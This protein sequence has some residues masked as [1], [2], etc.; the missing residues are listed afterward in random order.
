MGVT[1]SILPI[2]KPA[3]AIA[4]M[5]A[6]APGP[7]VLGPVP[8]TAL[9]LMWTAV[10]PFDLATSAAAE[11]LLIAAYGED[12]NLSAFTCRPPDENP[13]VSAPVRSVM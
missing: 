3:L 11:A 7:G 6:C 12:S 13:I 4:L 5:A 9:T 2:L 1:S 10:I 8:P